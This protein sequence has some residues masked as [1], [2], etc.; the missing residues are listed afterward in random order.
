MFI[1][2]G[3]HWMMENKAV[4]RRRQ[5]KRCA[6]FA[7]R[8]VN[9]P[10]ELVSLRDGGRWVRAACRWYMRAVRKLC[11]CAGR[12]NVSRIPPACGFDLGHIVSL[13]RWFSLA[14]PRFTA[15]S[16]LCFTFGCLTS[17][18]SAA[19]RLCRELM[20]GKWK[21]RGR[22]WRRRSGSQLRRYR[23]RSVRTTLLAP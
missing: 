13:I 15:G 11:V 8:E 23:T 5:C 12:P 9:L 17:S 20:V 14:K 19:L 1:S 6:A 22:K 3:G 18:I 4:E 10:A 7:P 21:C 16:F 2:S